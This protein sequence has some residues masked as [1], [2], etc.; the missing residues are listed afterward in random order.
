LRGN[1]G[2]EW[3]IRENRL[4]IRWWKHRA[5]SSPARGT[6]DF[7]QLRRWLSNDE[8]TFRPPAITW[9]S[10]PLVP[11][12]ESRGIRWDAAG[13]PVMGKKLLEEES[14]MLPFLGLVFQPTPSGK[15]FKTK[16]RITWMILCGP[17]LTNAVY[18]TG[19]E[20]PKATR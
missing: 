1:R 13:I 3:D 20:H 2:N 19:S 4:K 17:K 12:S 10:Q 7:K 8:A 18:I 16:S 15:S 5:G 11:S 14:K 9:S 6:N